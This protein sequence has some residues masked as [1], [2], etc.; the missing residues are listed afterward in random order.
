MDS[1]AAAPSSPSAANAD[2][3]ARTVSLQ[4]NPKGSL[5][6][7]S[8]REMNRLRD[9]SQGGSYE[10]LRKCALAVLNCGSQTDDAVA[11]LDQHRD[12]HI[13]VVE[14]VRGIKLNLSNA[15]ASAFVDGEMTKGIKEHLFSVLRDVIYMGSRVAN[16]ATDTESTAIT[17]V[18]FDILRNARIWDTRRQPGL[19]VC[20]GGHSI[21]RNEYEY[22]K[23]VGYELGLRG[24][25]ICTG[26]GPGAMKGPMKGATIG[27]AKQ[28]IRSGRYVGIS[29]PG[30]IAAESP[31]P[32]VNKL[33]IMP[34]IEKRLEAFVRSAH[35]I[36]VFP[37]GAG[38]AEETL[39]LLGIL[40]HPEN[41]E[42]VFPLVLTGP[43]GS[44]AYLRHLDQFIGQTLG[45]RA[46]E[47][48]QV[49]VGDPAAVARE[50]VSGSKRVLAQRRRSDDAYY[51]NWLL[52][53]DRAFQLRF[54]P[55]HENVAR[56]AFGADMPLHELAVNLRRAFSAVVAGNLKEEGIR[57]TQQ[58]GPYEIR[59][60]PG[61]LDPL[62]RLLRAFVADNRMKLGRGEDYVPCY[63]VV[64]QGG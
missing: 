30:I 41:R 59:G 9:A 48:Y 62:D 58:H 46:R 7:L 15:P 10:L 8:R 3:L 13:E 33:V 14:G 35:G 11:V 5:E 12:F 40:L 27:H 42:Q 43:A 53:I 1:A 4:I 34:D 54:E 49:V 31:N 29:E 63:R 44:E 36:V 22:T 45:A 39:F 6:V 28:R 25:D 38:T 37:G 20:W 51:F 23:D 21:S 32:I 61:V 19:V 55:T 60:A 47:L 52:E 2:R 16:R 57:A 18:V 50:L 24:L 17:D 64:R 26:C 56:L